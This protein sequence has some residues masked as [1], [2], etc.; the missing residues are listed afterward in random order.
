ML[1]K[2]Y[3]KVLQN[4][5]DPYSA[6]E[7]PDALEYGDDDTEDGLDFEEA[8]SG[9]SAGAEIWEL[10]FRS[11]NGPSWIDFLKAAPPSTGTFFLVRLIN[12]AVFGAFTALD[13]AKSQINL[14]SEDNLAF[15]FSLRPPHSSQNRRPIAV[16]AH[17]RE[18]SVVTLL[19][20]GIAFGHGF[21]LRLNFSH[22]EKSFS[23]LGVSFRP[24]QQHDFVPF[25][26]EA[27]NYFAGQ[28]A[29][30]DIATCEVYTPMSEADRKALSQTRRIYGNLRLLFRL[31]AAYSQAAAPRSL[32]NTVD[33][34]FNALL[35]NHR[36]KV[37]AELQRVVLDPTEPATV[38]DV[39]KPKLV[40]SKLPNIQV[41]PYKVL[42]VGGHATTA[43][44]QDES[45][46]GW[47][48][49]FTIS[50]PIYLDSPG[51]IL[52]EFDPEAS[53][54][55][56]GFDSQKEPPF[57]TH[58]LIGVDVLGGDIVMSTVPAKRVLIFA[59]ETL[60]DESQLE[61][62]DLP[63]VALGHDPDDVKAA[64]DLLRLQEYEDLLEQQQEELA[65]HLRG[66]DL[67]GAADSPDSAGA[68][69]AAGAT[70][71]APLSLGRLGAA[72]PL[73]PS[74]PRML[75][76]GVRGGDMK[77]DLFGDSEP[78]LSAAASPTAESPSSISVATSSVPATTSSSASDTSTVPSEPV[79]RA[80]S[81]SFRSG[82]R[83][84]RIS[85]RG[86][87]GQLVPVASLVLGNWSYDEVAVKFP[88]K[89]KYLLIKVLADPS[90]RDNVRGT[91]CISSFAA[92]AYAPV[93]PAPPI[94]PFPPQDA[95]HATGIR[96]YI[97]PSSI[98]HEMTFF[99]DSEF[100]QQGLI[101][102][103]G[104]RSSFS[105]ALFPF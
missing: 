8:D 102:W 14:L 42:S 69:G 7:W 10:Q 22:P 40:A 6:S 64:D 47:R 5:K 15:L 59:S 105:L 89:A 56:L 74:L 48:K 104:T 81:R 83:N 26:P 3:A 4:F 93:N 75:L 55:K 39:L 19:P 51:N 2:S 18:A 78:R 24:K 92:L 96:R 9:S 54:A 67:A 86:E 23:N 79:V 31:L 36:S 68:G 32:L 66:I 80:L 65:E 46:D 97:G 95:I 33:E 90:R 77:V 29:Q 16:R 98:S 11:S 41:A 87:Q 58:F 82:S 43:K 101:W 20:D 76:D 61:R 52:L 17:S 99:F 73:A 85:G 37:I 53:K 100:D 94:W 25:S 13:C 21:D 70:P 84:L 57:L 35:Q 27:L 63:H 103:L 50:R 30:W 62:F 34:K 45:I 88:C 44:Y 49:E 28:P 72:P 60:I 38:K 12:G 71:S 1:F 91:V